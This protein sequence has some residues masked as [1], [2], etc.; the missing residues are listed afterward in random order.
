M[1]GA[2]SLRWYRILVHAV[3]REGVGFYACWHV[4]AGSRAEVEQ[5]LTRFADR[6]GFLSIEVE[7]WYDEDAAKPHE[8]VGIRQEG[9]RSLYDE[10]VEA[11]GGEPVHRVQRWPFAVLSQWAWS[12]E[13]RKFNST[14]RSQRSC[15]A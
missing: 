12:R 10:T 9:G 2:P 7:E 3:E 5:V 14:L 8:Q 11:P 1:D 13:L 15:D 6:L 4:T